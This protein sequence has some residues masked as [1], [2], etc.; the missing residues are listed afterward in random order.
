MLLKWE[1]PDRLNTTHLTFRRAS[2]KGRMGK[3]TLAAMAFCFLGVTNVVE[4]APGT[5]RS[6]TTPYVDPQ[7]WQKAVV[8]AGCPL[9]VDEQC[10]KVMDQV[11]N[12]CKSKPY[13]V[14][15]TSCFVNNF[16]HNDDGIC[17]NYFSKC[18]FWSFLITEL[19][20]FYSSTRTT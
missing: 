14:T 11:W 8:Q 20:F 18:D 9:T 4:A 16:T 12:Q 19:E 2:T 6:P 1:H 7:S 5:S 15:F 13:P 3:L 10:K 17:E